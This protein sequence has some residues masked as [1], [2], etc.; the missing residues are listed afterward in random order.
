MFNADLMAAI[1]SILCCW[2]TLGWTCLGF[3]YGI[4]ILFAKPKTPS[5]FV[6][7]F[8][9]G[10]GAVIAILQ[11]WHLFLPVN[12][13]AQFVIVGGGLILSAIAIPLFIDCLRQ[14]AARRAELISFVIL[15]FLAAFWIADRS[16]GPGDE[17][18][19]GVYHVPAMKWASTYHVVP[20]LANLHMRLGFNS[21]T[22]LLAALLNQ[23]IWNGRAAHLMNGF[24]LTALALMVTRGMVAV[25]FKRGPPQASEWVATFFALAIVVWGLDGQVSSITTDIAPIVF[26]LSSVILFLEICAIECNTAQFQF[27]LFTCLTLCAMSLSAKLSALPFSG[28]LALGAAFLARG[29]TGSRRARFSLVFRASS[30]AIIIAFVWF[31]TQVILSGYPLYPST[32]L[33]FPVSWR[34]PADKAIVLQKL[35]HYFALWVHDDAP[36]HFSDWWSIW[37]QTRIFPTWSFWLGFAPFTAGLAAMTFA[38]FFRRR[39]AALN[40]DWK[41]LFWVVPCAFV[42]LVLWFRTAP[43]PRF[44]SQLPFLIWAAG[45]SLLGAAIVGQRNSSWRF[46]FLFLACAFAIAPAIDST[47]STFH[48]YSRFFDIAWVPPGPDHGF[49]PSPTFK[50]F[51]KTNLAPGI[52]L[53]IPVEGRMWDGPL[54]STP[55]DEPDLKLRNPKR[56]QQGFLPR[57]GPGY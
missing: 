12:G 13:W 21:S 32:F 44:I 55:Y 27:G 33:G 52:P 11:V 57:A 2:L 42:G 45:A 3:G 51:R 56:L 26:T 39:I 54:P 9:N 48:S 30:L 46:A 19:A 4:S 50:G 34:Y 16:C 37:L 41:G 25:A 17:V 40:C 29:V 36:H 38:F 1:L 20:G 35:I 5:D 28:P 49:H 22:T 23:G 10:F 43:D 7:S 6:W 8:W 14:N 15:A 24:M 31:A 47:R 53:Y 18:D